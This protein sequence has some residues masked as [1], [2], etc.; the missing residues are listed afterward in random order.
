[1]P[2][3]PETTVI[4][5][6]ARVQ[7]VRRLPPGAVL[8]EMHAAPRMSVD[9]FQ[10]VLQGDILG[11]YET[12]DVS[13]L[14]K[15]VS[16]PAQVVGFIEVREG[17]LVEAGQVLAQRGRGRRTMTVTAPVRGRVDRIGGTQIVLQRIART[18][19]VFAGIPG[20]VEQ[21]ENGTVVISGTGALIQCAWGNGPLCYE[22]F[23][24]VP[25]DGFTG[26][27]AQDMRISEYRRVVV[28]SP[29]PLTRRDLT[30][31]AGQEVAGVVAPSMPSHLRE[32]AMGLTFPIIL[33]EGFG[34]RRPTE[35]IYNLLR[36][37]MG[38]QAAFNAA[39]PD[40]WRGER[41]EIFIPLPSGGTLPPVPAVDR[42]LQVG[43]QVRLV[44]PP[45]DG[46]LAEVV[47]LPPGL[48]ATA[49]GLRLPGARVRL[50]SG[51]IAVVALANVELLG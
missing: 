19:E 5:G 29:E 18:V 25:E 22:T 3:H 39:V 40:R 48:Q 15:K 1:M 47:A 12:V 21:A 38:R 27:A 49:N 42:A 37:N 30:V 28:V 31:A 36:S 45:W 51:R 7:R 35:L 43:D 41:P 32:F 23:R 17:Q 10:I 2:Y 4:S 46:L 14:F 6:L 33:T 50:P 11:A 9:A 34:Q 16:D 24:F 44:C 26:L 20:E 13:P 8:R